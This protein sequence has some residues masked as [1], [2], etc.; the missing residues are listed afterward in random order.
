MWTYLWH[1]PEASALTLLLLLVGSTLLISLWTR[2][3]R[4]LPE[5]ISPPATVEAICPENLTAPPDL[6]TTW[7]HLV[8]R[9]LIAAMIALL[10]LSWWALLKP[11]PL[12]PEANPEVTPLIV[13]APWFFIGVQELLHYFDAWLG[14]VVLPLLLIFGLAALPYLD[15]LPRA[16]EPRWISTPQA[17]MLIALLLFWLLPT[18]MG[19]FFRGETW[20][21]QLAWAP[22][23]P[24][25]TP[26]RS[27]LSLSERLQLSAP[28]AH[29]VGGLLC[30]APLGT[31]VLAWA[32]LRRR[33]A[34]RALGLPRFLIAGMLLAIFAGVLL[35]VGLSLALDLRY[36][37]VTPWF[38][39]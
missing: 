27:L 13:K 15:P 32:W 14:G 6:V 35:K 11:I 19:L 2:R 30:L 29:L 16:T 24:D 18:V 34:I 38:S 28:M 22:T 12:G 10:L 3:P 39:I 1:D 25:Q 36:L 5:G 8:K 7:P 17:L 26:S 9:E 21:L 31:V 20:T 37:W 33:P 23:S 4:R